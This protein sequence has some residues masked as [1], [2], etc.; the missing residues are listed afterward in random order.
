MWASEREI[1]IE[2]CVPYIFVICFIYVSYFPCC[3]F[4]APGWFFMYDSFV[5]WFFVC[6]SLLLV[7]SLKAAGC[8][9]ELCR[10][11]LSILLLIMLY[12]LSHTLRVLHCDHCAVS[13]FLCPVVVCAAFYIRSDWYSCT[14]LCP[15]L[16]WASSNEHTRTE[17]SVAAHVTTFKY[18][19][20]MYIS[21]SSRR[22]E[23]RCESS[24]K[25]IPHVH[26][27]LI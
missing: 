12:N 18:N 24:R 13:S 7:L 9:F 5:W 10:L 20:N 15:Y 25:K 6:L 22:Y 14:Y 4:H 17:K 2:K 8:E 11:H 27:D 1:E 23:R 16:C 21:F 3:D 19:M 26:L